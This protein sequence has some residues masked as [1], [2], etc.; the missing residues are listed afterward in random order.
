MDLQSPPPKTQRS[1]QNLPAD[2]LPER[3]IRKIARDEIHRYR[4][5]ERLVESHPHAYAYKA[6]KGSDEAPSGRTSP[7]LPPAKAQSTGPPRLSTPGTAQPTLKS[8]APTQTANTAS[9][10]G[11]HE[12]IEQSEEE[13]RFAKAQSDRKSKP[14]ATELYNP[15]TT[16]GRSRESRPWPFG[17]PAASSAH[18]CSQKN[19]VKEGGKSQHERYVEEI[20]IIRERSITPPQSRTRYEPPKSDIDPGSSV[21]NRPPRGR[22]PRR[23]R[24]P[25]LVRRVVYVNK[26]E[27]TSPVN[28]PV[29]PKPPAPVGRSSTQ[30]HIRSGGGPISQREVIERQEI[31]ERLP[32]DDDHSFQDRAS[33]MDI[34][35]ARSPSPIRRRNASSQAERGQSTAETIAPDTERKSQRIN[36][37]RSRV[38]SLYTMQ[39]RQS[40]PRTSYVELKEEQTETAPSRGNIVHERGD[41]VRAIYG[42]SVPGE[43]ASRV[44]SRGQTELPNSRETQASGTRSERPLPVSTHDEAHVGAGIAPPPPLS[45]PSNGASSAPYSKAEFRSVKAVEPSGVS[46]SS[47]PH[48]TELRSAALQPRSRVEQRESS[49]TIQPYSSISQRISGYNAIGRAEVTI[50]GSVSARDNE[51]RRSQGEAS[52]K[53]GDRLVH[54]KRTRHREAISP[55]RERIIDERLVTSRPIS[56]SEER[57]LMQAARRPASGRSVQEP[58][59]RRPER[60]DQ[61]RP[62]PRLRS[63]LRGASSSSRERER[64]FAPEGYPGHISFASQDDVKVISPP[65]TTSTPSQVSN[66]TEGMSKLRQRERAWIDGAVKSRGDQP[67]YYYERER[68][69]TRGRAGRDTTFDKHEEDV[70]IPRERRLTR[71]LSESPSREGSLRT[72][73][74]QGSEEIYDPYGPYR[75]NGAATESMEVLTHSRVSERSGRETGT[76]RWTQPQ[77]GTEIYDY[78]EHRKDDA[79]EE[80]RRTPNAKR[81]V[82]VREVQD[83]QGRWIEVEETVVVPP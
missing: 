34:L 2:E 51:N 70:P 31:I 37:E 36:S 20:R 59:G 32:V 63:I 73:S 77:T 14:S 18:N 5:V 60:D 4:R 64:R 21:S 83:E 7:S 19:T 43:T 35:S 15:P 3:E 81:Y 78:A 13:S 11:R 55:Y 26:R 52:C 17:K 8:R 57:K 72:R 6:R 38:S 76:A 62:A 16:R 45:R 79:L 25:D 9:R 1:S 56:P 44:A 29:A 67:T 30:A 22:S 68:E 27:R 48:H 40:K 54:E 50:P 24:S 71:A 49:D 58:R 42:R 10:F 46:R 69:V 47:L 66:V 82:D 12:T 41:R 53:G 80:L 28:P 65:D 39:N 33:H 75:P 23:E 74:T 61:G